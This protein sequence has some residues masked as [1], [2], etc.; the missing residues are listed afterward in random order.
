MCQVTYFHHQKCQH[1][2][3]I[4]SRPCGP[5]L[6][7]SNCPSFL[8]GEAGPI[9]ETPKIY[10]TRSRICP[11]C[12]KE[13]YRIGYDRNLVRMVER[14][15]WGLRIGGGSELGEEWGVD[16]SVLRGGCCVVM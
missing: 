16:V 13:E 6:G 9:K 15:G 3:A 8:H 12:L 5:S 7:F 4:I 2:W 11:Q 1:K 10:K 14:M